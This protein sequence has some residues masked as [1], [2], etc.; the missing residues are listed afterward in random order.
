M[1]KIQDKTVNIEEDYKTF[2]KFR[3]LFPIQ[4]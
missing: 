3:K 1:A 4:F 2:K